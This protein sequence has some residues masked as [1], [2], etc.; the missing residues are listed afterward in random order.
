MPRYLITDPFPR[1]SGSL[2]EDVFVITPNSRVAHELGVPARSL[3]SVAVDALRKKGWRMAPPLAST[4]ALRSALAVEQL[5]SAG[6]DSVYREMVGSVIRSGIDVDTLAESDSLRTSGLGRAARRYVQILEADGLVDSDAALATA[7][8][9]GLPTQQKV[10]IYGYFRARGLPARPEELDMINA[11]A[12]EDSVFH[13]PCAD[14]AVFK[15]NR[16]YRDVLL[17]LGWE[18]A[19][20]EPGMPSRLA[21][22]FAGL[23]ILADSDRP[24][25]ILYPNIE[26]E[27]RGV[28]A[29]AKAAIINGISISDIV[30]VCRQPD[31]YARHFA[32][33]AVEYDLPL[34]IEHKHALAETEIGHFVSLLL[35]IIAPLDPGALPF[36]Y[37]PTARMFR[38]PAGPSMDVEKWREARLGHPSDAEGWLA[39]EPQIA[40]MA[41]PSEPSF[42]DYAAWLK[43]LLF[44]WN[45]R[46]AL[47]ATGAEV[48]AY[49]T[50]IDSLD[51]LAERPETAV[52][53]KKFAAEV[54]FILDDIK[55][56]I[57][58]SAVGVRFCQPNAVVGCH[59]KLMFVV[60]LVEGGLPQVAADDPLIDLY[61]R[62]QLI[63]RGIYFQDATEVPRW[64]AATFYFTLLAGEEIRFSL[65][66]F[67]DGKERLA[68]S[69]L[70][71]IKAEATPP[72]CVFV[73]SERE[74]RQVFLTNDSEGLG[75][76]LSIA[77]RHQFAVERQR[78]SGA[79][80]DEYNGCIGVHVSIKARK[81]SVSQLTRLGR[82]PFQ[83]FAGNLLKLRPPAE[84]ETDV[85][86]NRRGSLYHK[87]LELAL[88]DNIGAPDVRAAAL[89]SLEQAFELAENE[90][91]FRNS[92]IS[93]W[94]LR[95]GEI[96]EA[97]RQ[98]VV[99]EA[100]LPG[101]HEIAAVE[102]EFTAAWNG[103]IVT[104]TIDRIDRTV[105]GLSAVDYKTG[106]SR[107]TIK[108]ESG[109]LKIDIQLA[110]YSEALKD[111]NRDQTVAPGRYIS[112]NGCEAE[113]EEPVD[114]SPLASQVK[115][116]FESGRFAVD[117]D[118]NRAAC[119]ICDYGTV[120][121][122]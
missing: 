114:L 28:L 76:E 15:A 51:E 31:Q 5:A 4:K 98:L 102:H 34:R 41:L 92:T 77:A 108:D 2:S 48:A 72:A 30:I 50:F 74:L 78:V 63:R 46:G 105:D 25:A 20:H 118:V 88:R 115:E 19:N 96:L 94:L 36:E 111:S 68:S 57:D 69:Y 73:S 60:G 89:L 90:L 3:Q 11:F 21:G 122:R 32:Q 56:D 53:V 99:S 54:R 91:G 43:K 93:N 9:L 95:R 85:A 65:P 83:W 113:M 103:L 17:K 49:N 109:Q 16:E 121:R 13:L 101:G 80:Q 120:C 39:I 23:E 82:C 87:T 117:P 64:E 58:T 14:P 22:G 29:E 106:S 81:F 75:D 35:D 38:H 33:T 59:Y 45:A 55:T 104:G 61:E 107:N 37:E 112:I 47:G 100:F 97:L 40:A 62:K 24:P 67:V 66:K 1:P 18:T 52:D 79:P 8:R 44:Y 119:R 27:I 6:A 86:A 26:A 110:I 70:G 10:L 84:A 116:I 7:V 12:G 42:R 71:R